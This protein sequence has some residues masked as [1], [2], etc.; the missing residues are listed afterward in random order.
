MRLFLLIGLI[1]SITMPALSLVLDVP[2]SDKRSHLTLVGEAN[3]VS[4]NLIARD[5]TTDP[6]YNPNCAA[7]TGN[8]DKCDAG[9]SDPYHF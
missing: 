9:V 1:A 7:P 8:R 5:A 4:T 6:Q 3:L 2:S